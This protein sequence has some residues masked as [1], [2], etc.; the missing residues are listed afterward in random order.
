MNRS[1]ARI[2]LFTA[3]LM[4]FASAPVQA[5]NPTGNVVLQQSRDTLRSEAYLKGLEAYKAGSYDKAFKLWKA[6]ANDGDALAQCNLGACYYSGKGVKQDYNKALKWFRKSA[7]QGNDMAQ[8]NIGNCY[9]NGHGVR[10][11]VGE[12]ARWYILAAEQGHAMAL[13]NLGICY[14]IGK[15]VAADS[16]KAFNCLYRAAEK[17]YP[18]AWN[19]VGDCFYFGIVSNIFFHFFQCLTL[20]VIS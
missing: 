8:C 15:G 1:C 16:V 13:T 17:G 11:D 20:I 2:V 10:Q 5:L 4:L 6:A 7:A 3:L 18:V 19:E 12:A 9:H 14:K